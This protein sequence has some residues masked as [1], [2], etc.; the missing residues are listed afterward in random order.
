MANPLHTL[1]DAFRNLVAGSDDFVLATIIETQGST[2]QKAG[3]RML[4]TNGGEC[5]GLLGGGCFEG[6]L[7]ER[8]RSVFT[9]G[10]AMT[11]QYDMRS[12]DDMVWGLGLGC[13]GAV[14]ILLQL[15]RAD[16]HYY[17]LS[18]LVEAAESDRNGVL[19]TVIESAHP[20]LPVGRSL[21]W[22]QENCTMAPSPW[23]PELN[24]TAR[25]ASA[26]GTPR[27]E[28]HRLEGLAVGV[29]YGPVRPLP[30]LLIV[31]A[32][33]DAAPLLRCA[34]ALGW[35]VTLVDHRP[36]YLKPERFPSAD[37]LFHCL[38]QT[39]A[40]D[41]DLDRF[42][43][44]VLMTHS[45]DY[46]GRYL[47]VVAD[48]RIPFIGL[49]GPKARKDRLVGSLGDKALQPVGRI[50]G[51]VGLDIGAETPE[52]I[53]LAIMAGILA[54]QNGRQGGQLTMQTPFCHA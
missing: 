46:D 53:A 28:N 32:G 9:S 15:L 54:A 7:I 22:E 21:F 29:F 43:A 48:S 26:D 8:S 37:R 38:P 44:A 30:R 13:N 20:R 45:F 49:L 42:A 35:R 14:K 18:A 12:P 6:D 31:G 19:A 1:V 11:V 34:K 24:A 47:K 5:L 41:L 27:I 25:Q 2:Y 3:A 17:P 4:I 23:P 39:L 50:F 10:Q 33:A 51:P 16:Q 40:E 36:A 52:E